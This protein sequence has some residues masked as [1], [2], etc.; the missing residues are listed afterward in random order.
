MEESFV[1]VRSDFELKKKTLANGFDENV[2][3]KLERLSTKF[4][5]YPHELDEL[6][7]SVDDMYV[8]IRDARTSLI[9]IDY[10]NGNTYFL[11]NDTS[12]Q[13]PKIIIQTKPHIEQI[14]NGSYLRQFHIDIENHTNLLYDTSSKHV[15]HFFR[16]YPR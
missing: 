3:T 16:Y 4:D 13:S 6:R 10:G 15:T 1:N 5:F 7:L 9:E 8:R 2:S 14:L 11:E 12:F